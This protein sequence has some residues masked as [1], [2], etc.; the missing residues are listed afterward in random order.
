MEIV[1]CVDCGKK[2]RDHDFVRGA[3]YTRDKRHYCTTCRPLNAPSS[4]APVRAAKP[5]T[6]RSPAAKGPSAARPRSPLLVAAIAG[7]VLLTGALIAVVV[8][9]G[10]DSAPH[11]DDVQAESAKREAAARDAL[12]RARAFESSNPKDLEGQV[13]AW[14]NVA[15]VCERTASAKEARRSLDRALAALDR[16]RARAEAAK[17]ALGPPPA[18][19]WDF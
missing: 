11:R 7:G 9:S 19:A 1:Y 6:T 4:E 2:L 5:K 18:A 13:Q 12:G 16:E 14:K 17:K 3:A 10:K 15:P 8:S